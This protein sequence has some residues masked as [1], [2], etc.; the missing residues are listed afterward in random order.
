MTDGRIPGAAGASACGAVFVAGVRTLVTGTRVCAGVFVAGVA[1]LGAGVSGGLRG[2]DA[3]AEDAAGAA[4]A[5]A[6]VT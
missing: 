2:A 5:S 6:P 1:A 3:A 4:V